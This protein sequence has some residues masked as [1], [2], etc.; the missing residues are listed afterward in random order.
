MKINTL[1][2]LLL[3]FSGHYTKGQSSSAAPSFLHQKSVQ[4]NIGTQGIGAEFNYGILPKLALS[5]GGNIIPFKANNIFDISGL[6]STSKVSA[7]FYNLH[8]MADYTPWENLRWLRIVGGLGYF[9]KARGDV[10]INPSDR[11]TY[12]DLVLTPEQVGHVNL[13]VDWNGLAPYGGIALA[14][15]F[16]NKSF[17][18][19]F[20]LGTYYLNRPEANI[21]GT[22]ILSG[23][24]SQ[25]PQLQQNVRNYRWLPVLQINF[26]LKL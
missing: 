5:V 4:L 16:P 1:L 22:G 2:L 9:F 10:T 12:G 25:S 6:N 19:D 26:N 3:A 18:V 24:D 23:N 11:Y 20:D 7:D 21:K 13:D 14:G 15:I 8:L 17:N